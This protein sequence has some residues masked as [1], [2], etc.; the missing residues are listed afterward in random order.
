[1]WSETEAFHIRVKRAIQVIQDAGS[2]LQRL[3]VGVSGGKD[4]IALGYLCHL[5]GADFQWAHAHTPLET[6]G[7]LDA[8]DALAKHCDRELDIVD[9]DLRM[10]FWQWLRVLGRPGVNPFREPYAQEL[11][12]KTSAG[13]LLY[14]Y[15][16]EY[17]FTGYLT[18]MRTEESRGRRMNRKIRGISYQRT[19]GCYVSNPIS[20]WTARD[21][22]A[23]ILSNNLPICPHYRT[24][25]E[26][27][28]ISPESPGS[29]VDFVVAPDSATS[30]PILYTTSVLYPDLFR[31]ICEVR[32]ECR[33]EAST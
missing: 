19:D 8:A 29:R 30:L 16:H 10:D 13:A 5:A 25:L 17:R 21:V 24:A 31:R 22:W 18:G 32:P 11:R 6:P 27:L 7:M 26:R 15:R 9:P 23:F 1:M 14:W 3:F 33:K 2:Q 4:S 12:N 20:D 28:G